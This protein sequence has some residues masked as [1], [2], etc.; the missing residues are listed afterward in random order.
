MESRLAGQVR[1]LERSDYS[2]VGGDWRV[3]RM[4]GCANVK[5]STGTHIKAGRLTPDTAVV[6]PTDGRLVD[7]AAGHQ[8]IAVARPGHRRESK[9]NEG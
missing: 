4:S 8:V 1:G 5:S 6:Q 9:E 3:K 2:V 7:A